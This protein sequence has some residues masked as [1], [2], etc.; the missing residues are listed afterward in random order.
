VDFMH[1]DTG[2]LTRLYAL[3]AVEHRSRRAHL[4]GI[5]AH[6]TG[7]WTTQSARNLI[8]DLGD[9]LTTIT[10][11]LCDAELLQYEDWFSVE[12]STTRTTT[13]TSHGYGVVRIVV[14]TPNSG[15]I[16]RRGANHRY[17]KWLLE[18]TASLN[19]VSQV[20]ILPGRT[21]DPRRVAQRRDP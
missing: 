5:T 16:A 17:L 6:P 10:F 15:A 1:V 2:L 9:H 8:M 13:M 19:R 18:A 21:E 4:L 20:R 12:S 3:I 7:A 14:R 11:L